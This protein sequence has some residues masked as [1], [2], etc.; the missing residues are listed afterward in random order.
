MKDVTI[1]QV[2]VNSYFFHFSCTIMWYPPVSMTHQMSAYCV[3]AVCNTAYMPNIHSLSFTSVH[4]LVDVI[5]K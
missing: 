4:L 3:C 1:I 2:T 5:V